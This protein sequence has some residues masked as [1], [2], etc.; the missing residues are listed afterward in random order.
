MINLL[1]GNYFDTMFDDP[2]RMGGM[3]MYG[4]LSMDGHLLQESMVFEYVLNFG[5]V[6]NIQCLPRGTP[7]IVPLLFRKESSLDACMLLFLLKFIFCFSINFKFPVYNPKLIPIASVCKCHF[8]N[9]HVG[10]RAN[11]KHAKFINF[12]EEPSSAVHFCWVK[13]YGWKAIMT[14]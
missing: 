9:F 11:Q 6:A 13:C 14:P 5:C 3:V 4:I 7:A 10:W 8:G 1:F 12:R 2:I